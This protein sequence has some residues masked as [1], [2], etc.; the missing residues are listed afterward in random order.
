MRIQVLLVTD[1]FGGQGGIAKFN[2]D[3]LTSLCSHPNCTGVTAFPRLM[4]DP[5]GPLPAKLAYVTD[6]LNSKIR[7]AMCVLKNS[8]SQP[9]ADLLIC[10]HIHLLP[11]ARLMQFQNTAPSALIIHGVDAW[12]PTHSRLANRCARHVQILPL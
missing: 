3:L 11:L 7:Y 8:F 6:G 9:K 5:S 2:R 4:P 12:Q 1:A 10:G